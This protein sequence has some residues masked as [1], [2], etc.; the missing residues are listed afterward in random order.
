MPRRIVT[1]DEQLKVIELAQKGLVRSQI[2]EQTGLSRDIIENVCRKFC[3]KL[4]TA[5]RGRKKDELRTRAIALLVELLPSQ[6]ETAR[7]LGIAPAT[8][9]RNVKDAKHLPPIEQD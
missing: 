9:W 8:V 3:V 7:R 5:K 4:T 6:R 1:K 2:M